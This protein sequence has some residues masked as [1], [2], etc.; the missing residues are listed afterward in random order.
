MARV[1]DLTTSLPCTCDSIKGKTLKQAAKE[2][3][4]KNI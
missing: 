2:K 1:S 3:K 4:T